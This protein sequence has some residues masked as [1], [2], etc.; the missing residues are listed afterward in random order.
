MDEPAPQAPSEHVSPKVH[1]SPSSQG[2]ALF[3]WTHPLFGSQASLVQ[4]LPSSQVVASVATHSPS[5]HWE[6]DVHA[7]ASSQSA[8]FGVTTHPA[9]PQASSVHGFSSSQAM[10]IPAAQTPSL[11][12]SPKVHGAPSSQSAKFGV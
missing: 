5:L 8:S 9:S 2:R 7:F 12:V 3:A 6:M 10:V 11:Q 4:G 1:P